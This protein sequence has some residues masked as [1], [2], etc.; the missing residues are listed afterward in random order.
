MQRKVSAFGASGKEGFCMNKKNIVSFLLLFLMFI[1]CVQELS[2]QEV[3]LDEVI[4]TNGAAPILAF[5]RDQQTWDPTQIEVRAKMIRFLGRPENKGNEEIRDQLVQCMQVGF[6]RFASKNN[7]SLEYWKIRAESA[8]AL[9]R[10][11][12]TSVIPAIAYIARN[13]PDTQVQL[14]AV[15]A[16]G[17]L[18]A[19]DQVPFLIDLLYQTDHGRLA[20]EIVKTLGVIGDKRAFPAL[21]ALTMGYVD[22]SVQQ[23]AVAAMKQLKW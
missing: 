11:G 18:K 4:F 2:A 22:A 19:E 6:K 23:S 1:P 20:Q 12:E 9:A 7:K 13:D 10:M 21:L 16:L 15:H 14:C 17:L 8:L 3:L 5:L